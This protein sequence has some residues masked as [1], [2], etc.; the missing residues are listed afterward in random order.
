[1]CPKFGHVCPTCSVLIRLFFMGSSLTKDKTDEEVVLRD[2]ISCRLVRLVSK[3]ENRSGGF[4]CLKWET[5]KLL[6]EA[7]P[8]LDRLPA[9]FA[10]VVNACRTCRSRTI[11]FRPKWYRRLGIHVKSVRRALDRLEVA[12][13]LRQQKRRTKMNV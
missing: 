7:I 8:T 5:W 2:G 10:C 9:V 4:C 3:V 12:G 11:D 13:L 1:M 6:L